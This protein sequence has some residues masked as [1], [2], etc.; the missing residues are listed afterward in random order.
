MDGEAL[1]FQL[2][3]KEKYGYLHRTRGS[4]IAL[5]GPPA[6]QAGAFHC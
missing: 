1:K 5:T 6:Q 3:M 4:S 2:H